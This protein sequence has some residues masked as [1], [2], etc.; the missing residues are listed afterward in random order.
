MQRTFLVYLTLLVLP[1]SAGESAVPKKV[2]RP[3]TFGISG[4]FNYAGMY[5]GGIQNLEDEYQVSPRPTGN[6]GISL[7]YAVL[8]WLPVETGVELNG[9]GYQ[10]GYT[11]DIEGMT[12]EYQIFS[13]NGFWEFPLCARPTATVGGTKL[14]F[15]GGM[16]YAVMYGA[17]RKV[18]A[19]LSYE[20]QDTTMDLYDHDYMAEGY[21]VPVDTF[22]NVQ[23]IP[24]KELFRQYDI[25]AV[26]GFGFERMLQSPR[27]YTFDG[28]LVPPSPTNSSFYFD[29]RYYI[30]LIDNNH[31]TP[32]GET[33]LREAYGKLFQ[34]F[35]DNNINPD[36][37]GFGP[38]DTLKRE[39]VYKFSTLSI[40]AGFKF[41]F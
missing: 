20:G 35:L 39:P 5:G 18:K 13:K 25:S 14:S 34:F 6:G 23:S 9:K 10:Y 4:G 26:L 3:W 37:M 27:H 19:H 15:L 16:S 41:H 17:S 36:T 21:P 28:D 1:L 2:E 11:R 30:G 40:R 22:G 33:L 12:V 38:G 7:S 29:V 32:K 31:V 8:P 24:Y